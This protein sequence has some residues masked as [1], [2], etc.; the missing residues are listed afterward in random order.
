GVL[1][2]PRDDTA[3]HGFQFRE[4]RGVGRGDSLGR[5]RELGGQ[6]AE[7]G[8]VA[9]FGLYLCQWRGESVC[10]R[11][12]G[13]HSH[14]GGKFGYISGRTDQPWVSTRQRE[15]KSFSSIWWLS[16]RGSDSWGRAQSGASASQLLRWTF[17]PTPS[18]G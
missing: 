12:A 5:R 3:G 16:E 7:R 13:E 14:A 9:S 2:P 18:G 8:R 10:G 4:Q 17:R 15:R 6:C 11:R 1:G